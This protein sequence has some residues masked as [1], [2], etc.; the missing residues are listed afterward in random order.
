MLPALG[1]VRVEQA[2]ID[3]LLGAP[4]GEEP[5]AVSAAEA[6]GLARLYVALTR[7]VTSLTVLHRDDLPAELALP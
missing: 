4:L 1:E 7:A 2:T 3:D 5:A 6:R